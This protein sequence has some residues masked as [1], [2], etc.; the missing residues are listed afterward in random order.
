[1]RSGPAYTPARFSASSRSAAWVFPEFVGP[2]CATTRSGAREREGSEIAIR[3]SACFTSCA[4]RRRARSER[5]G[6]FWRPRAD[7]RLLT[8]SDSEEA[9]QRETRAE[10]PDGEAAHQ[11]HGRRPRERERADVGIVLD[12]AEDLRDRE[13]ATD[14]EQDDGRKR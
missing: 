9:A 2:R 13:L 12:V 1:M 8:S 6:R 5:L 14:E 10:C 11:E 7:R 4:G 3:R